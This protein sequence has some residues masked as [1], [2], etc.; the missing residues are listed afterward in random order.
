MSKAAPFIDAE[1]LGGTK[2]LN[3]FLFMLDTRI[4]ARLHS[5]F[6]VENLLWY[7]EKVKAPPDIRLLFIENCIDLDVFSFGDVSSEAFSSIR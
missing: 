3:M 7:V 6:L 1:I 4:T 2:L 5:V